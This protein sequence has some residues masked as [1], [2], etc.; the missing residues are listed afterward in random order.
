MEETKERLLKRGRLFEALRGYHFK[1]CTGTQ[2]LLEES[3]NEER[4][5]SLI[6][7]TKISVLLVTHIHLCSLSYTCADNLPV[8]DFGKSDYRYSYLLSVPQQEA[9]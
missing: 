6:S 2:V 1:S 5:V 9:P 4:P 3:L 8:L 7:Q